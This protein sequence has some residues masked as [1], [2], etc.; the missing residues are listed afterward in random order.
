MSRILG[1]VRGRGG[2]WGSRLLLFRTELSQPEGAGNLLDNCLLL[3]GQQISSLWTI[4][5]PV[6]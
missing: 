6:L 2:A 3:S 5:P 4:L 1:T